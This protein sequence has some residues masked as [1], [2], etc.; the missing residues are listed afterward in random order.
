MKV[1][2]SNG[3]NNDVNANGVSGYAAYTYGGSTYNA[4]DYPNSFVSTNGN[5]AIERTLQTVNNSFVPTTGDRNLNS[6]RE[7][8]SLA[9]SVVATQPLQTSG[10]LALGSTSLAG[11]S[12]ATLPSG[13]TYYEVHNDIFRDGMSNYNNYLPAEE[14]NTP[15]VQCQVKNE[16]SSPG[17]RNENIDVENSQNNSPANLTVPNTTLMPGGVFQQDTL[18][19][20]PSM[21]QPSVSTSVHMSQGIVDYTVT[22]SSAAGIVQEPVV[23]RQ[24]SSLPLMD[25]TTSVPTTLPTLSYNENGDS[26][27]QPSFAVSY[28]AEQITNSVITTQSSDSSHVTTASSSFNSFVPE[29]LTKASQ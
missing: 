3:V 8:H 21:H 1:E 23:E 29:D 20:L 18:G 13:E 27:T 6:Q 5:H 26:V 12:S 4:L 10:N 22:T 19:A 17:S 11:S 16:P 15:Y 25:H 9:D 28:P 7:L 24:E 2:Q 14:T